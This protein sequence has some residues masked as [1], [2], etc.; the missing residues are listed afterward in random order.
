LCFLFLVWTFQKRLGRE[1]EDVEKVGKARG[2]LWVVYAV[3]GL[4]TVCLT[5]SLSSFPLCDFCC[6]SASKVRLVWRS[7]AIISSRLPFAEQG[8][9]HPFPS[10]STHEL[11]N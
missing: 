4:I 7:V 11:T 3:L 5:G 8:S 10:H 1:C 6:L 2:L 9:R